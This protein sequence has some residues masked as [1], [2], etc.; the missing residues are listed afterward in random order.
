MREEL[1]DQMIRSR[2]KHEMN[3][4]LGRI[5][6][7]ISSK[8]AEMPYAYLGYSEFKEAAKPYLEIG[9]DVQKKKLLVAS[10]KKIKEE[11]ATM[12]MEVESELNEEDAV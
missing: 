1:K 12:A 5:L 6:K 3:L 10:L 11:A 2:F 4:L 9:L 7:D 8:M